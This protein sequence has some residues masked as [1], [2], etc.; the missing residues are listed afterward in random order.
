VAAVTVGSRNTCYRAASYGLTR[1]GLAPAGLHQLLLAPSEM[2]AIGRD[3]MQFDPAPGS[4][5]HQLGVMIARVVKK[6]MDVRQHRKERLD[7]FQESDRRV[8]VDGYDLDHPGLPG[9]EVDRAVNIDP[10]APARLFD[11]DLLLFLSPNEFSN[12]S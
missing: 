11:S 7:R 10:L 8:G 6:D 1:T 3:E 4:G 12:F 2:R 9:R 5:K